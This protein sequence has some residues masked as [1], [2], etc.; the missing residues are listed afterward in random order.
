MTVNV[1]APGGQTVHTAGNLDVKSG[2]FSTEFTLDAGAAA[3]NYGIKIS[4]AGLAG[5]HTATFQ[6]VKA[7]SSVALTT[8]AEG[9]VFRP[10]DKVT[11]SGTAQN[12]A[13]VTV[14]VTAPGGQTVHTAETT[15]SRSA[16][17]GWQATIWR[18]SKFPDWVVLSC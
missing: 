16:A 1:T 8:P 13:A 11:I 4:G 3:G 12:L 7:S 14:N 2:S 17:R 10:G 9:R 6:V 15:A 18:P 5:E